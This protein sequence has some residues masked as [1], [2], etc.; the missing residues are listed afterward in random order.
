MEFSELS[1]NDKAIFDAYIKVSEP[2]ASEMNFTN[3]FI[4]KGYYNF[5]YCVINDLLCV[6]SA[7]SDS[8]PFAFTPIGKKNTDNFEKAIKA[9]DDYFREK[10]WSLTLKKVEEKDLVYYKNLNGY[11]KE[12]I[13]DRDN[14]DYVYLTEALITLKGKKLHAKRNHINK[15]NKLYQYEY[16]PM[17]AENLDECW[18]ITEK[19]CQERECDCSRGEYCEKYAIRELL[20]NFDSLG[21]KGALI[22]VDGEYKAFTVGEMLNSNTAVIHIEKADS[23]IQGLYTLINQ[24]FCEKQWKDTVYINREQDLGEEGLRKSKESYYPEKMINKYIVVLKDI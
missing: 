10:G 2:E 3:F 14:S 17:S 1:I 18:K 16:V 11:Q 22:K 23:S 13:F 15:F 24:Q 20:D 5:R 8:E 19:W 6:I 21:Y 4:W 12:I 7:P 9:L